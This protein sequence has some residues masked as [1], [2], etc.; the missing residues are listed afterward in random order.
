[1]SEQILIGGE[2]GL[3]YLIF[4]KKNI[5]KKLTEKENILTIMN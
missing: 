5:E 1:M 3:N 4:E 2:R